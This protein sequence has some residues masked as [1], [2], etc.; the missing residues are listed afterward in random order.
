M[1]QIALRPAT[2]PLFVPDISENP[3]I[4]VICSSVFLSIPEMMV[5]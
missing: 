2:T 3:E 1:D 5:F 4:S